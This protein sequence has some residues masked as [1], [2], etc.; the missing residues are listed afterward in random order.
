MKKHFT[1]VRT[2]SLCLCAGLALSGFCLVTK[3]IRTE[4]A[5]IGISAGGGLSLDGKRIDLKQL[6]QRL[7][8]ITARE[9]S[10]T[11]R[12]DQGAP[13]ERI[14]EVMDACRSASK[15]REMNDLRNP[16]VAAEPPACTACRVDGLLAYGPS[17]A[18]QQ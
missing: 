16:N 15:K 5:V 11:I 8:E 3:H 2:F 9:R 7:K 4:P 6:G 12:A 13:F 14:V 18:W 10:I 1:V 17:M